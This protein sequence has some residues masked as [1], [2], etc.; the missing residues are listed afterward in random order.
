MNEA[1]QSAERALTPLSVVVLRYGPP[2]DNEPFV[3]A[4][5][6]TFLGVDAG[7]SYTASDYELLDP[8]D[9]RTFS[10]VWNRETPEP[11]FPRLVEESIAAESTSTLVVLLLSVADEGARALID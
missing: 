9:F 5:R 2:A 1:L 10:C 6:K 3:G 8:L 11:I 7:Q 4:L